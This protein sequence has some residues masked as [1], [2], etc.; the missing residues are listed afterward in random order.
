VAPLSYNYV[1]PAVDVGGTPVV[2]KVGFPTRELT[3]EIEALR[4]FDGRGAVRLL[5]ADT[6]RGALLL[7]RLEPGTPLTAIE[8]D[9]LATAFAARVMRSLWRPPPPGHAF[10][11]VADWARGMERLRR[12]FDGGCGPF[13]SALVRR[14]EDLFDE[15][16]GSMSEPVLLHGD[17]HHDNILAAQRQP[18]LAIDPKGVVGEPAYEVGA[19]LRNPLPQLLEGASPERLLARRLDQLAAELGFDRG[20]LRDWAL[21]QAVLSGWWSFEDHGRGWENAIACA[22]IL[23]G[24]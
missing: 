5:E 20:R 24:T 18:W 4:L 2:L 23:G 13:P 17:L 14:A 7:E 6:E 11:S 12:R 8:D 10:P 15:L 22:R 1:A 16:L 21:A 9:A 19:F 3:T